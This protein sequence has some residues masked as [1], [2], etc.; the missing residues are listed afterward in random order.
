ME[1]V[2]IL[3]SEYPALYC[4]HV[5]DCL[6]PEIPFFVVPL[7]GGKLHFIDFQ[8]E[9]NSSYPHER[10]AINRVIS[11]TARSLKNLAI[12][13]AESSRMPPSSR[14]LFFRRARREYGLGLVQ[15]QLGRRMHF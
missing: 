2:N 14:P 4:K 7:V 6:S 5:F 12:H 9:T 1:V 11:D 3:P 10:L 15:S 8:E 13:L